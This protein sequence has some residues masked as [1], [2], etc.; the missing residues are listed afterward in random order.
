MLIQ[1]KQKNNVM[2][3]VRS[4]TKGNKAIPIIEKYR[5]I[6][7]DM[8]GSEAV[9]HIFGVEFKHAKIVGKDGGVIAD[10]YSTDEGVL[11]MDDIY[12][13]PNEVDSDGG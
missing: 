5:H 6:F 8:F 12:Q 1:L 2:W 11:I 4:M 10:G 13:D 7:N 9:D 3:Q